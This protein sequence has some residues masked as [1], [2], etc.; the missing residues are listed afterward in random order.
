MQPASFD[1][2]QLDWLMDVAGM[3]LSLE[4][5]LKHQ[6]RGFIKLEDTVLVRPDGFEILGEASR[7]WNRGN[8]SRNQT[9]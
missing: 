7:G 2:R 5:T 1:T 4:T 6:R 8:V 9:M 3:V